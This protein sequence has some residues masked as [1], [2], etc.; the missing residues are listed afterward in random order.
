[1]HSDLEKLLLALPFARA[2]ALLGEKNL[3]FRTEI[4]RPTRDFFKVDE[5]RLYVVRVREQKKASVL[6]TLAAKQLP[7]PAFGDHI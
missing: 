1:L 7:N 6:L 5:S 3:S 4:T 2:K